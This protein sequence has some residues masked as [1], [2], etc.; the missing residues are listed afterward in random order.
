MEL[1]Y[2]EQLLIKQSVKVSNK[3]GEM[4]MKYE[5]PLLEIVFAT[6]DVITTSP[7]GLIEGSDK[8]DVDGF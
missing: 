5:E 1:R 8:T 2:M 4:M 6:D 7:P 3:G